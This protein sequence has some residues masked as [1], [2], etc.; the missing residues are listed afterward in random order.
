MSDWIPAIIGALIVMV[1][2]F[3]IAYCIHITDPAP[4]WE[5]IE[6]Q[7]QQRIK[8]FREDC[9]KLGGK[10]VFDRRLD[11]KECR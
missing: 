11:P 9:E 10:P 8:K 1:L 5:Q 2:L 6:Q 3:G 4:T 7:R